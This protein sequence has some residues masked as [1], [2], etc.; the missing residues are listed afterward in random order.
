MPYMDDI[1]EEEKNSGAEP[2]DKQ[3]PTPAEP[4]EPAEPSKPADEPAPDQK[5]EEATEPDEKGKPEGEEPAEPEKD[6]PKKDLS[7][8]T[9]EQKAEFAFKRQ[10]EKQRSKYEAQ[11]E[12]MNGRFDAIEKLLKESQAAKAPEKPK[13]RLDF[14]EGEGGDDAYIQYLAEQKVNA[15]MAKRDEAEADKAAKEAELKKDE[16]YRKQVSDS[17]TKNVL[18]TFKDEESLNGYNAIVKRG[19]DN[20][21]AEI[22]D[23]YPTVRN[24]VFMN[25]NGPRVLNAMLRDRATFTRVMGVAYDPTTV[26]I[27]MHELS[28]ELRK[29]ESET[30]PAQPGAPEPPKGMPHIGKP[31]SKQ[32]TKAGLAL[33]SDA[34]IIKFIRNVR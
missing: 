14:P 32:G 18:D 31:G 6:K 22:L 4:A 20:G 13:T 7:G 3:E 9:K 11:L 23:K 2:E 29:K 26:T 21:L 12:S 33:E 17:Y 10:M 24:Y 16:D 28:K 30:P 8:L 15:I 1:I 5:Q 34:D 27:E 25:P 19:M